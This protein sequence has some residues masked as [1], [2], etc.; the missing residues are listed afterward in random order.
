M[1]KESRVD[2]KYLPMKSF[3]YKGSLL[4]TLAW[5]LWSCGGY[6]YLVIYSNTQNTLME[7]IYIISAI[8]SVNALNNRKY[9]FNNSIR[10]Y[11]DHVILPKIMGAWSWKEEKIFYQDID[12]INLIDYGNNIS[13]NYFEIEV[14]TDLFS[15][16][17]FGKKLEFHE[18]KEIYRHLCEKAKIRS[19]NFPDI[20]S[21][22]EKEDMSDSKEEPVHKWK[23]Y[24][25]LMALIVSGW[26]IMGISLSTPYSNL[27]NGGK[28][29]LFSFILSIFLTFHLSKKFKNESYE[30][31]TKKW[32][33]IFLLGYIGLYGGIAITF[34]LVFLNGKLDQSESERLEMKVVS[35]DSTN[36]KKG[37]CY[38][39]KVNSESRSPSSTE[40]MVS[41]FGELH[42]CS[43]SLRGA[44]VG[45]KY[46]LN[47][48]S[49][50]FA[51][52][53]INKIKKK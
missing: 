15:Y 39:L 30:T 23:G 27:L 5:L 50:L 38:N 33:R 42:I 9:G 12:E 36:S 14:R 37:P 51:E 21:S 11:K 8:L 4:F 6:L 18:L 49:G 17:I 20:Y 48:K 10:F 45:D 32:Q 19:I 3:D 28:I 44:K 53:W 1:Q 16:P 24:L 35:S 26:T 7:A 43:N 29:F 47:A 40:Q 31:G 13:K 46:I 41:K 52:K 2:K 34:S 25:A 22:S